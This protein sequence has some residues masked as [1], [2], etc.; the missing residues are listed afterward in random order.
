MLYQ[1]EHRKYCERNHWDTFYNKKRNFPY[2]E[3]RKYDDI[4]P[5]DVVLTRAD[6]IPGRIGG[7]P[8]RARFN[9]DESECILSRTRSELK[10]GNFPLEPG[11]ILT[12]SL[13]SYRVK[14]IRYNYYP[15]YPILT[16]EPIDGFHD[17]HAYWFA[18]NKYPYKF[19]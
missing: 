9:A 1:E 5:V 15:K 13:R 19:F 7:F 11:F 4:P 17:L 18:H 3:E 2:A 6:H 10:R 8:S 16:V 14:D 12:D